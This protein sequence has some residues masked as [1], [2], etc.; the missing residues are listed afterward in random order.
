MRTIGARRQHPD[1]RTITADKV[2]RWR[3][4]TFSETT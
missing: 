1:F 2:R 4:S 3:F